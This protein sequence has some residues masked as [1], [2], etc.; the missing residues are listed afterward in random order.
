[1]NANAA[2][3]CGHYDMPLT[4]LPIQGRM[5]I[6]QPVIKTLDDLAKSCTMPKEELHNHIAWCIVKFSDITDDVEQDQSFSH[7]NDAKYILYNSVLVAV[8]P[9][10]WDHEAVHMVHCTGSTMWGKHTPQREY[11]LRLG[12]KQLQ[13]STLC[14]LQDAFPHGLTVSSSSRPQDRA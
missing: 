10:E 9:F 5:K 2:I 1:M 8:I 7:P 12:S 4:K 11:T 14:S 13:I 6:P 3:Q